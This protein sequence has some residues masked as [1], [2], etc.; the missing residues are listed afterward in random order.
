MEL[1]AF[2]NLNALREETGEQTYANPRNFTAGSLKMQDPTIVAQR[3]IRFFAYDLLLDNADE[4]TQNEKLD[5]LTDFGLPVCD[6]RAKCETIEE[7]CALIQDWGRQKHTYAFETDGAVI[8]VNEEKYREILGQTAKAP[9]WAIAYKFESEQAVTKINDITLQ[10]GRLGTITPVAELEPVLLAGTTVKRASLHNEDEI[11]RKDI[12]Q[13]DTVIIE[14]AGEIIPQVINV[15]NPDAPN[16][17]EPYQ[18][19]RECP[20][21]GSELVRVAGEAAWRC[22]NPKCPPQIRIRIQH[23]AS[24]HAMD[25]EGLGEA[26]VDQLVENKLIETFADLYKLKADEI[27]QL[28]RM[29]DK[30]AANLIEAIDKSKEQ[31]FERVLYGLGIRFV[32]NKVAKDLAAAFNNIDRLTNATSEELA[33]VDSIGPRIADSVTGFFSSSE[34]IEL[35]KRLRD[36]GL[37]FESEG[38]SEIS[39]KLSGHTF[40]ITGTLPTLKRNEAKELIGKHGGKVT[41]SISKK[42]HYLLAGEEPGS[43]LDKANNLEIPIISEDELFE[44]IK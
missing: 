27:A 5:M 8:K 25:I 30:S 9:R 12:R 22:I 21:C 29:G 41:G 42:T 1:E 7:V 11:N 32:G 2:A 10:V 34:N 44:L 33:G 17:T 24:R 19:P 31:P 26:V 28:E 23:F 18:F 40:V 37:K 43:K 16:R 14:K 35:I 3:P 39:D 38:K 4:L 13:G 15:V 6:I 20:A 36:Y